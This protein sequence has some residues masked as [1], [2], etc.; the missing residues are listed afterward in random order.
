[1]LPEINIWT[2]RIKSLLAAGNLDTFID[3][4]LLTFDE[5]FSK[6]VSSLCELKVIS[7]EKTG[8]QDIF[9]EEDSPLALKNFLR[10]DSRPTSHFS[11]D[12]QNL[13]N[14]LFKAYNLKVQSD[15]NDLGDIRLKPNL[16]VL[17]TA[18]SKDKRK[19]SFYRW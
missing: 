5:D 10:I 17:L 15:S 3:K 4:S 9:L 11:T 2:N 18:G 7:E 13:L 1:M 8:R 16:N 12:A 19:I 6:A 14:K